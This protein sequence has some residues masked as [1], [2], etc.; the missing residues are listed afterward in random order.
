MRKTHMSSG[1]RR[2]CN[3]CSKTEI[4]R[5][6]FVHGISG[7]APGDATLYRF[8]IR[9]ARAAHMKDRPSRSCAQYFSAVMKH[10]E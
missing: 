3:S 6:E 2:Q 1:F 7:A 4:P 8:T 5:A 9:K 10:Q